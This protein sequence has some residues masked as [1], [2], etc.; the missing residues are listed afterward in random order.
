MVNLPGTHECSRPI[1]S[2]IAQPTLLSS[3]DSLNALCQ[4]L[5]LQSGHRRATP[6]TFLQSNQLTHKPKLSATPRRFKTRWDSLLRH[7]WGDS[8][9][10]IVSR[11]CTVG[12]ALFR[13][14]LLQ[15]VGAGLIVMSCFGSSPLPCGPL[16]IPPG[17]SQQ[18]NAFICI[19][20]HTSKF[21]Y[22]KAPGNETSAESGTPVFTLTATL[23]LNM[24]PGFWRLVD[25]AT[26]RIR[27]RRAR[28]M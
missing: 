5:R 6:T 17:V 19:T 21:K 22:V 8:V 25:Q 15:L 28:G 20:Q 14:V 16:R 2:T 26:K 27:N 18:T 23:V 12:A 3:R 9:A 10:M 11:N 4:L 1:R 7:T 24:T 13:I